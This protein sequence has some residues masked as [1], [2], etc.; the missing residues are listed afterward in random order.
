[1]RW[2]FIAFAIITLL[3]CASH[4]KGSAFYW[5]HFKALSIYSKRKSRQS[6]LAGFVLNATGSTT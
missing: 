3:T 6:F 2:F 5:N 1:M 4:N